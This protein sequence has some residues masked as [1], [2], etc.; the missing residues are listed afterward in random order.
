MFISCKLTGRKASSLWCQ[1]YFPFPLLL[2][3]RRT[4]F[5]VKS[6]IVTP[7]MFWNFFFPQNCSDFFVWLFF[8]SLPNLEDL[9]LTL[10]RSVLNMISIFVLQRPSPRR[11]N[12]PDKFKRPT[13]PPSPNTQTPVQPPPPPPPPPVQPPGQ[14]AASQAANFQHSVHPSSQP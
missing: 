2:H 4:L 8:F 10:F 6:C 1:E 14:G 13:P 3:F 7:A 9:H 11:S 12:S 5:Y